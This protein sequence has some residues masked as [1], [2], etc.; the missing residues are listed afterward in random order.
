VTQTPR[1]GA[2]R[3]GPWPADQERV[4]QASSSEPYQLEI[5][6]APPR[7]LRPHAVDSADPQLPAATADAGKPRAGH[8]VEDPRRAQPEDDRRAGGP[9]RGQHE[10]EPALAVLLLPA[11]D[12]DR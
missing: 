12:P 10:P 5:R 4:P 7:F 9:V 1:A 8:A 11:P 3:Q 2:L 6:A